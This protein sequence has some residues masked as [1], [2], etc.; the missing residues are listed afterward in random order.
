MGRIFIWSY[1]TYNISHRHVEDRLLKVASDRG[2]AVIA[3]RPYDGGRLM[4][5][6]KTKPLPPLAKEAG[7]QKWAELFLK[8]IISHP[9]I[10]VAIPATSKLKHMQENMSAC[11]KP[12]WDKDLRKA[13][14]KLFLS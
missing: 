13:I 9:S 6:Y 3:N 10:T 11:H 2:I 5:Q 1:L 12:L 8:W 4:E 14:G 7:I